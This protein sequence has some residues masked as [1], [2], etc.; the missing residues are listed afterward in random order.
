MGKAFW[1]KQMKDD[2]LQNRDTFSWK[3]FMYN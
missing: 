1:E 2:D 3:Y